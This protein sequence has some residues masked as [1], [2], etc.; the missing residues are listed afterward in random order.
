MK[1]FAIDAHDNPCTGEQNVCLLKV[2][3]V[4]VPV[5][6]Q[7]ILSYRL[8]SFRAYL[9]FAMVPFVSKEPGVVEEG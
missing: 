2:F 8:V 3:D 1:P 7:Q 5:A 6:G 9:E 4:L